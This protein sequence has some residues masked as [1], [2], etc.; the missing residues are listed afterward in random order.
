MSFFRRCWEE[1]RANA[2]RR[3]VARKKMC[4]FGRG[5]KWG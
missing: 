4:V 2:K 1:G 5:G 3:S